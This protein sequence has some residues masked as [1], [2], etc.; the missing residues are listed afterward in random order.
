MDLPLSGSLL[1]DNDN[2][3]FP[4]LRIEQY[5]NLGEKVSVGRTSFVVVVIALCFSFTTPRPITVIDLKCYGCMHWVHTKLKLGMSATI[6]LL[7]ACGRA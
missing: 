7:P 3:L 2:K 6:P 5:N 1:K 4:I